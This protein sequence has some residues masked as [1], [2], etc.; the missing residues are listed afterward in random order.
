MSSDG[1]DVSSSSCE[2]PPESPLA[3]LT[4]GK[5]IHT[6]V[7]NRQAWSSSPVRGG[8]RTSFSPPDQMGSPMFSPIIKDKQSRISVREDTTDSSK[9]GTRHGDETEED[10]GDRTGEKE[11]LEISVQVDLS[12]ELYETAE[13][14]CSQMEVDSNS[15]TEWP[16]SQSTSCSKGVGSRV[17]TGNG[18]AASTAAVSESRIEGWAASTATISDSTVDGWAASTA[19][20]SDSRVETSR[21]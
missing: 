21:A 4:P 9:E 11:K 13:I 1:E 19:A 3:M 20:V 12:G 2:S 10:K 6:P 14:D 17:D 16:G 7:T 15:V 8:G 18:W 5:V